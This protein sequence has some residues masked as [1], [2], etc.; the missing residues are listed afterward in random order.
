MVKIRG[1]TTLGTSKHEMEVRARRTITKDDMT[2]VQGSRKEKR[3]QILAAKKAMKE[4]RTQ[5]RKDAGKLKVN[6]W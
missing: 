1:H 4:D 5:G 6:A 3:G 2:H